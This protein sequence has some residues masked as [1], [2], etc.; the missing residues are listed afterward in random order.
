MN[1]SSNVGTL[2]PGVPEIRLAI[3][4]RSRSRAGIEAEPENT[5]RTLGVSTRTSSTFAMPLV[6]V[7]LTESE[8]NGVLPVRILGPARQRTA[9]DAPEQLL[10][11]EAGNGALAAGQAGGAIERIGHVEHAVAGTV[12][13]KAE[14]ALALQS[15]NAEHFAQALIEIDIGELQL[16]LEIRSG[17]RFGEPERAFDHAAEGLG[18][19]DPHREIAVAQAGRDGGASELGIRNIDLGGRQ[20]KVDVEAVKTVECDRLSIPAA[21]AAGEEADRGNIGREVEDL[22]GERSLQRLPAVTG[23]GQHAFAAVAVELDVDLDSPMVPPTTL[24]CALSAKRPKPPPGG[25]CWRAQ[26]NVSRS[27]AASAAS[28]PSILRVGRWL[29]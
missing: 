11:I 15:A 14:I 27:D 17:L 2:L 16:C 20:A 19:P 10:D 21:L 3:P 23:E 4:L 9:F 8:S 12:D 6:M 28:E 7:R 29:M 13:R 18:F 5:R 22:G 24:V 1:G 25:G 26:R